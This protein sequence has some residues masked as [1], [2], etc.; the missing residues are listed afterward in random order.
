MAIFKNNKQLEGICHSTQKKTTIQ[1]IK[2][3]KYENLSPIQS[4]FIEQVIV[5]KQHKITLMNKR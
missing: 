1:I 3:E 5:L 4:F 2:L